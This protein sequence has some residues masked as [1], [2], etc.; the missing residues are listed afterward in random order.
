MLIEP[1]TEFYSKN[2]S[3]NRYKIDISQN[4]SKR[5][6][7]DDDYIR[8]RPSELGFMNVSKKT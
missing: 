6:K 7:V 1:K 2:L 8:K 3:Q 5:Y 4:I